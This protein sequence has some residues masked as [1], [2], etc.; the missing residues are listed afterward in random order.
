[1]N[2]KGM[3]NKYTFGVKKPCD[4][5]CIILSVEADLEH[6]DGSKATNADGVS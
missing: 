2:V 4:G 3:S 5:E 1:M 6:V